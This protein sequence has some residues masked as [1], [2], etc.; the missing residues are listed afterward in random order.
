MLPEPILLLQY[1]ERYEL[2]VGSGLW[3]QLPLI[4][5]GGAKDNETDIFN[6]CWTLV[7]RHKNETRCVLLTYWPTQGRSVCEQAASHSVSH[8]VS[9]SVMRVCVC[10]LWQACDAVNTAMDRVF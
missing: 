1:Y 2:V 7:V 9:Q 10:V 8:S 5:T 4:A 3:E 6:L